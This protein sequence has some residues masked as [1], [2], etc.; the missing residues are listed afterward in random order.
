ME[1]QK[2]ERKYYSL[3]EYQ[4]F[5]LKPS[6]VWKGHIKWNESEEKINGGTW[7]FTD[8]PKET[9]RR[10]CFQCRL[11]VCL[12]FSLFVY[13]MVCLLVCLSVSRITQKI[14]CWFSWNF[15]EPKNIP[16]RRNRYISERTQDFFSL[17]NI[18]RCIWP[19]W[20]YVLSECPSSCCMWK[21]WSWRLLQSLYGRKE[22][23]VNYTHRTVLKMQYWHV[24]KD[25]KR[26][27]VKNMNLKRHTVG[28][29]IVKNILKQMAEL[30]WWG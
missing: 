25:C 3:V 13:L 9:P 15:V 14:P 12:F 1:V 28:E 27:S 26:Q 30:M 6:T 2:S 11:L 29:A 4:P 17:F 20:R 21:D 23:D 8:L 5:V 19:G 7:V 16:S 22:S 10:L 18:E 24:V